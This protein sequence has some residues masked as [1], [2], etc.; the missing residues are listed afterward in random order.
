RALVGLLVGAALLTLFGAHFPRYWPLML[1][2]AAGYVTG[3]LLVA[4]AATAESDRRR[5]LSALLG[6]LLVLILL[7]AAFRLQLGLGIALA[8]LGLAGA[9]VAL[10]GDG[11][12]ED[13]RAPFTSGAVLSAGLQLLALGALFRVFYAA[14]HLE[15]TSIYLT[16]HYALIGLVAGSLTPIRLGLLALATARDDAGR[17]DPWLAPLAQGVAAV[18]LP[19]AMLLVWG[20]KADAGVLLGLVVG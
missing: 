7:I 20:L 2:P 4:L 14:Q 17:P 16:A 19:L 5:A 10:P 12:T 13:A 6:A 8:A 18:A 15:S 11:G 1:P 3:A 9:A